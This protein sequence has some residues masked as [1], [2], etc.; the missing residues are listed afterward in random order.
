MEM[1]VVIAIMSILMTAGGPVF[2][3]LTSSH[4]PASV[5]SVFS[6]QLERARSHA[7]ARN[8]YVWVRLGAVKLYESLD[9]INKPSAAKGVWS[10]P[11]FSDIKLSSSLDTQFPALPCQPPTGLTQPL[12]FALPRTAWFSIKTGLP[13]VFKAGVN[14]GKYVF[15]PLSNAQVQIPPSIREK[16]SEHTEYEA[17]LKKRAALGSTSQAN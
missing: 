3:K 8:T 11:R 10:A 4:S 13:V 17:Y 7:V 15:E 9:G 16:M 6:G 5:A 2:A 12:G 14:L 1:L